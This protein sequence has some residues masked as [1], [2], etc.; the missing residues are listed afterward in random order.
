MTCI[1]SMRTGRGANLSRSIPKVLIILLFGGL[2]L[3]QVV[4]QT[5]EDQ[6]Y[7]FRHEV[8]GMSKEEVIA[9]EG[10]PDRTDADNLHFDHKDVVG[11]DVPIMFQF[12]DGKLIGAEVA[13]PETKKNRQAVSLCR[14]WKAAL[15][16]K[17]GAG[18]SSSDRIDDRESEI[19]NYWST[20]R[21][22]ISLLIH[23]KD[24]KVSIGVNF[25]DSA[26]F[27]NHVDAKY[28]R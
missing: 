7:D 28:K 16:H 27:K 20:D 25:V 1:A 2:S 26:W 24:S 12:R 19:W 14:D 6:A 23:L 13:M 15:D 22:E 21:S 11:H 4:G 10:Q 17:Y 8:W 9:I 5:A 18:T 3:S